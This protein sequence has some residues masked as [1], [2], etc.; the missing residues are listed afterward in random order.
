LRT[1][2]RGSEGP[3]RVSLGA[4][5]AV[6]RAARRAP[7]MTVCC[8]AQLRESASA[9]AP[10]ARRRCAWPQ[11][12]QTPLQAGACTAA[13]SPLPARSSRRGRYPPRCRSKRRPWRAACGGGGGG[14]GVR[15]SGGGSKLSI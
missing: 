9:G 15:T 1:R 5:S 13:P 6:A 7:R 3:R 2:E 11:A 8:A 4:P 10:S 14:G 12:T